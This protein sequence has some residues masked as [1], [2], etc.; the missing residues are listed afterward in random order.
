MQSERKGIDE[1][2]CWRRV[3]LGDLAEYV[4]GAAFKP[5]ERSPTGTPIIRIQNLTDNTKPLNRTRRRVDPRLLVQTGDLL[6]SWSATLGAFVWDRE[7][8]WLNQHIFKVIPREDLVERAFL[9]HLLRAA[10]L[11]L[12]NSEHL[13][14][15]TMRHINRGPFLAHAVMLP[16]KAVQREIVAELEREAAARSRLSLDLS[17]AGALANHLKEA[18]L[19]SAFN[20]AAADPE[21][22]RTTIGDIAAI[23]TKGE[24]PRWQGFEYVERGTRFIRSQNV[25]WGTM[26]LTDSVF[27][28]AEFNLKREKSIL[29]ENDVLL[30]IVGAS[31]GRTAVV[32]SD[33]AGANCNQAVAII[34]LGGDY[35]DARFVNLWLLSTDAQEQI[36]LGSVDVARANFSLG[37]IRKLELPWPAKTTRLAVVKTVEA[38][39]GQLGQCTADIERAAALLER[40]DGARLKTALNREI[41]VA[42]LPETEL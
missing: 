42:P 18:V 34:R 33:L 31:I 13:H 38:Q 32:P 16:P 28:P 2:G 24:S 3:S 25:G 17:R 26:I 7:P 37:D 35:V 19:A 22:G 20:R 9:Y 4:N 29:R 8:A 40:L 15:S 23:V 1:R 39:L 30:N 10:T 36:A 41:S 14:G 21:I 11:S 12:A 6:F 5:S 27:L